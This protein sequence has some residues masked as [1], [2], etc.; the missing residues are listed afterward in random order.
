MAENGTKPRQILK[1]RRRQFERSLELAILENRPAFEI[2]HQAEALKAA[3]NTE[4][5]YAQPRRR[6]I[7][8]GL[9]SALAA[10]SLVGAG[11]FFQISFATIQLEAHAT[12]MTFEAAESG[13][14]DALESPVM[15]STAPFVVKRF[16]IESA[17]AQNASDIIEHGRSQISSLELRRSTRIRLWYEGSNCTAMKVLEPHAVEGKTGIVVQ[18]GVL[19]EPY[20]NAIAPGPLYVG[21]GGIFRL[22]GQ[23][24][25]EPFLI[26]KIA[27]LSLTRTYKEENPRLEMSSIVTGRVTISETSEIRPLSPNDRLV[28]DDLRDAWLVIQRGTKAFHL[29]LAGE[30]VKAHVRGNAPINF[31]VQDLIP[32]LLTY[33]TRSPLAL[34]LSLAVGLFGMFWN[35]LGFLH[36]WDDR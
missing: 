11:F 34:L 4:K 32:S 19:P 1:T 13:A 35:I 22:C 7:F 14:Y 31:D 17:S 8:L 2:A 9:F 5:K 24:D 15:T 16:S 12:A 10:A 36:S 30:A 27:K 26:G 20:S 25:L 21:K 33:V 29:S 28:L 3:K 6:A 18:V 23:S